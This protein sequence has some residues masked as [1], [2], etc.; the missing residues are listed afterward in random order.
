[1]CFV[2]DGIFIL[3]PNLFFFLIFEI[4]SLVDIFLF[5]ILANGDA[6]NFWD[7]LENG[8]LSIKMILKWTIIEK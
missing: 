7:D 6:G 4:L 1:M 5:L 2:I 8:V 3:V